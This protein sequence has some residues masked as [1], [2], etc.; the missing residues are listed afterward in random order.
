AGPLTV[1]LA[2]AL[3]SLA[4][5]RLLFP[6]AAAGLFLVLIFNG[7]ALRASTLDPEHR[8]YDA[9]AL[10]SAIARR[11]APDDIVLMPPNDR[12]LWYYDPAPASA[13]NWPF[14]AGAHEARAAQLAPLLQGHT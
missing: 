11:A 2:Q 1:L 13:G 9:S 6:I 3:A 4:A 12:S 10:A 7:S 8:R 5:H 14:A